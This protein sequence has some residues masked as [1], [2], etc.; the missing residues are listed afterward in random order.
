MR[1]NLHDLSDPSRGQCLQG[2]C[3]LLQTR[4]PSLKTVRT[5]NESG[6]NQ[7]TG[8][9]LKHVRH[10][11]VDSQRTDRNQLEDFQKQ[12]SD[13]QQIVRKKKTSEYVRQSEISQQAVNQQKSQ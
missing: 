9:K 3:C 11:S 13:R 5:L 7:Q 8:R 10:Q 4:C 6:I 12:E 1:V 2:Y